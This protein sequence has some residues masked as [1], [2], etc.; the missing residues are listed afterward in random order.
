MSSHLKRRVSR[1]RRRCVIVSLACSRL[2]PRGDALSL[3]L[4]LCLAHSVFLARRG[5]VGNVVTPPPLVARGFIAWLLI[6]LFTS[7]LQALRTPIYIHKNTR[8]SPPEVY[9]LSEARD[10]KINR[11]GAGNYYT[12]SVSV[13]LI[14]PVTAAT[15]RERENGNRQRRDVAR[16]KGTRDV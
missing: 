12:R 13:L 1:G 14:S 16:N 7:R 6:P 11:Y 5:R 2:S 3:S 9:L 10:R 15:T 8:A 4:S